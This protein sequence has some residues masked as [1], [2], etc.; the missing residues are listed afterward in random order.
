M[1]KKFELTGETKVVSGETLHRIRALKDFGTVN[2][3]DLGG[4]VGK[5][6]NLSQE[7][8]CWV[9]GNAQVFGYARV[10]GDAQVHGNARVSGDAKVKGHAIIDFCFVL[11][12][13]SFGG[14]KD[15]NDLFMR[16]P[17]EGSFTAFKKVAGEKT[18]LILKIRVP[19]DA[20]R[21]S[22][23]GNKCRCSK[24]K[25][26][27]LY[28]LDGTPSKETKARSQKDGYFVY[29]LGK[30]SVPDSFDEDR[31]DECSHGIH[32]FMSFEEARDY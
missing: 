6:S 20:K 14:P 11:K 2:E 7:S 26:I 3:G 28:N 1:K 27:A 17:Q 25:A 15:K 18:A 9:Y 12:T 30:I 19:A 10:S 8:D 4:W 5:E 23:D 32:F 21:S 31:W 24:A 16:C 13:G 22:A 29:E